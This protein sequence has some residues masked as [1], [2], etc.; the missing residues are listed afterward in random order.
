MVNVIKDKIKSLRSRELSAVENVRNFLDVIKKKDRDINAFIAVN[1]HAIAEAKEVDKKLRKGRGGKLAGLAIAVKSNISVEDLPVTCA[2]KTLEDYKG[3]FDADA[4]QRIQQE[5]GIII[6]MTNMDEL[7]CGSS[8]ETSA[9][10]ATQN[11]AALGRI[12]GGSSSGS[13]A[14]VAAGMCDLALG[15]DTGGSIRNPASHCGVVGIKPSYGRVSRYGLVDMAMS[16]EG[17]GTLSKEVY[18][19]A[20]LL[21]VIAGNS[22][23]DAVTKK[24]SVVGSVV[25]C[26]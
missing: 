5:D 24:I 25:F 20:L 1:E 6:G 3:T 16:L 14:A 8:G 9:F 11:P 7:A 22:A 23:Y 26:L 12:P 2:S 10:G 21:E 15:A 17:I 13:A 4:I 19:S 18:G